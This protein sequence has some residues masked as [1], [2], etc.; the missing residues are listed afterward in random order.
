MG[1]G[2]IIEDI[3]KSRNIADLAWFLVMG[4]TS[5]MPKLTSSEGVAEICLA[6]ANGFVSVLKHLMEHL[7]SD[8]KSDSA[9]RVD[10][11]SRTSLS[12]CL[13]TFKGY[14]CLHEDAIAWLETGA[15][16]ERG[17]TRESDD[18]LGEF[19][20][21]EWS[22][23]LHARNLTPETV[24]LER[25]RELEPIFQE[26]VMDKERAR[27]SEIVVITSI[28]RASAERRRTN[29]RNVDAIRR[30]EKNNTLF[31]P[32][33]KNEE[34]RKF[35]IDERRKIERLLSE[36]A[37]KNEQ[38]FKKRAGKLVMAM[39]E[40]LLSEAKETYKHCLTKEGKAPSVEYVMQCL[41]EAGLYLLDD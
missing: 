36:D 8:S 35:Y 34:E 5:R 33:S 39:S 4:P 29:R 3:W 10:L 23:F 21:S 1:P 13:K 6:S 11:S 17:R 26:L 7:H 16:R 2:R 37:K 41:S 20:Q 15:F 28:K 19:R 38:V 12:K 14:S 30:L 25:K 31:S 32:H 22:K 40:S 24:S 27:R 9:S 18:S